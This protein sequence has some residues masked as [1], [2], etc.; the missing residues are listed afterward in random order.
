VFEEYYAGETLTGAVVSD[1]TPEEDK[2]YLE[3]NINRKSGWEDMKAPMKFLGAN[4]A[5]NL[6][7]SEKTYF[8]DL[9]GPYNLKEAQTFVFAQ[10]LKYDKSQYAGDYV[11]R[12][13]IYRGNEM[14]V[15]NEFEIELGSGEVE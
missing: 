12:T 11:L 6:I 3:M 15:E 14:V 4:K 8:S 9:Y 1:I 5:V 10:Q 2:Y 13:K 7:K